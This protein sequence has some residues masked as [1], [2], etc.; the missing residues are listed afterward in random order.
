MRI[1]PRMIRILMWVRCLSESVLTRFWP[2]RPGRD[3]LQTVLFNPLK[4]KTKLSKV[5]QFANAY[6]EEETLLTIFGMFDQVIFLFKKQSK[7]C[8]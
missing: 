4:G 8:Y 5:E 7:Q 2:G 3:F 1:V 6:L